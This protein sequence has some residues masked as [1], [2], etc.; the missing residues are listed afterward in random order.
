MQEIWSLAVKDLRLLVRDKGGLFFTFVFPVLY[1]V[2]FGTIF[3]GIGGGGGADNPTEIAV[4]D[5][6]GSEASRAFA[7]S[8][9]E[10]ARLRVVD[11]ETRA[12]AEDAVRKGRHAALVVIP[13]GF[14]DASVFRGEPMRLIVGVDPARR[15]EGGLI[16]GLITAKAY[17]R[18]QDE[19]LTPVRVREMARE[20]LD[21]L[22]KADDLTPIQKGLLRTFMTSLDSFM[23]DMP[24]TGAFGGTEGEGVGA[25]N[26]VEIEAAEILSEDA[27]SGPN[28][29][30]IAFPQG[31]IWGILGSAAGFGISLVTERNRGTLTRLRIAPLGRSRV[32]LG[33]AL[34]CFLT[35][36]AV[37]AALLAIAWIGFGVRPGS[38]VLLALSVLCIAVCFVGLMMLLA[39]L[40]K[41]EASAGGI[42]WAVLLVMA[43]FGGGMIPL[44]FMQGWMV[45]LSHLSPVKWSILAMEGA[46]WRGFGPGE[47][48]LP[49]AVL[50][51]IGLI[52]FAAG[53]KLFDWSDPS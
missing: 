45:T 30:A 12:R 50:V 20:T 9:D 52:A 36:V 23:A 47:M 3:A 18:L 51:G 1:A 33:K 2:F 7:A 37:A 15:A 28:P 22:D 14:G 4:V 6:D 53:A 16:Q 24:A 29:Y 5:E 32:L 35:T 48:L 40:G 21:S 26:P 27:G 43:M 38:P 49:C 8:L 10:E 13:D 41:T 44:A 17:Q 19:F 46:I 42:G 31:I 39:T 25:F 11:I 34:A